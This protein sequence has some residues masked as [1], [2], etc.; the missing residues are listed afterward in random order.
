MPR[1][2]SAGV[3]PIKLFPVWMRCSKKLSGLP[4]SR[5][6]IQS[7]TLHNSTAIGLISTP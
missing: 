1:E 2:S 5:A 3:A 4:G 6:S 7:E